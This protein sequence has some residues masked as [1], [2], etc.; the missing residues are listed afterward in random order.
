MHIGQK[1]S[2]ILV[3]RRM[4]RQELGRL[5]G[6]S[7]SAA[8]YL[9]TRESIDVKTLAAIGSVVKHDFFQYYPIHGSGPHSML[10]ENPKV[11][12]L[13]AKISALEKSLEAA[14]RDLV[15]Q[16]QENGYLKKINE[17]LERK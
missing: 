8:T 9:T 4:T 5:I 13:L 6:I 15:M 10:D 2:E 16:K 17:L 1:I 12:E 3:H 11:A 14:R 7:G